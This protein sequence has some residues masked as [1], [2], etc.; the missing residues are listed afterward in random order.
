MNEKPKPFPCN[1]CQFN[2]GSECFDFNHSCQ[3][4]L[5]WYKEFVAWLQGMD[6]EFKR[7]GTAFLQKYGYNQ[8]KMVLEAMGE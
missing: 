8:V 2:E 5:V 4:P 7:D 3:A 1:G 6:E